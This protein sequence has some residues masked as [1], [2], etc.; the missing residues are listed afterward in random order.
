MNR[1]GRFYFLLIAAISLFLPTVLTAQ[2]LIVTTTSLP[3][4]TQGAP[5][6]ATVTALGRL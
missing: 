3:N 2:M 1:T 6:S 5:Y 4:A